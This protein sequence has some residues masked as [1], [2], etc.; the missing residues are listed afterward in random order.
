MSSDDRRLGIGATLHL[1][2]CATNFKGCEDGDPGYM[3]EQKDF[4]AP[5]VVSTK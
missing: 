4:G 2:T 3:Y 5:I 1:E